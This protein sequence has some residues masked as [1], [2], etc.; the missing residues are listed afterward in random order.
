M[1]CSLEIISLTKAIETF[2]IPND[3]DKKKISYYSMHA[4]IKMAYY[5]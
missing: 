2:H 5:I 4:A 3:V 1:G